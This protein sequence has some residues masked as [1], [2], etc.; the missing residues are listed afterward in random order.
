[1][2]NEKIVSLYCDKSDLWIGTEKSGVYKLAKDKERARRFYKSNNS[3]GNSVNSITGKNNEVY[4][5]TQ[6]GVLVFSEL[7]I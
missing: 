3:L 2:P 6:N 5:S 4:V 1:M 7:K